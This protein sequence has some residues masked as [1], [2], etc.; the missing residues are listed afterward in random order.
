MSKNFLISSQI[1]TTIKSIFV[2]RNKLKITIKTS[3][4]SNNY[5]LCV[6]QSIN[7]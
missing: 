1:N 5:S 4:L 7:Y 2:L 6:V 3:V